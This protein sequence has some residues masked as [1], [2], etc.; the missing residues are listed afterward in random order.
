MVDSE[1]YSG[2]SSI[3]TLLKKENHIASKCVIEQLIHMVKNRFLQLCF[4]TMPFV[5]YFDFITK[6]YNVHLS[7][8]MVSI[9]DASFFSSVP[10]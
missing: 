6:L 4:R 7:L 10:L 1:L 5:S 2:S 9:R 3:P 8:D